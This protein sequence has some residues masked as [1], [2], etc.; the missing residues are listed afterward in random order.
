MTQ[1]RN[2]NHQRGVSSHI[3][4]EDSFDD[5]PAGLLAG[6]PDPSIFV[7][8]PRLGREEGSHVKIQGL[9]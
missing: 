8:Q 4:A 9:F 7:G 1:Q 3:G 6:R 5:D 2:G